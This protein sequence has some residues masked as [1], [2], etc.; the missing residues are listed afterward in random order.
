MLV[1]L[2]AAAS[3]AIASPS[4]AAGV[5]RGDRTPLMPEAACR[6]HGVM[7]TSEGRPALLYRD[8]GRARFVPLGALPKANHEKAVLRSVNGCATPVVVRYQVGR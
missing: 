7:Q 8:D 2:A 1:L 5:S 4:T 3:A 6:S